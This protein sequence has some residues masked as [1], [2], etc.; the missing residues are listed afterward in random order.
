MSWRSPRLMLLAACSWWRATTWGI[1]AVPAGMLNAVARPMPSDRAYTIHNASPPD[2]T[3]PASR[4]SSSVLTYLVSMSTCLGEWRST[5]APPTRMNNA[6]GTLMR[7]STVPST[8][9]SAVMR[10]TSQGRAIRVN[11]SPS[12]VSALP[13]MSQRKLR[14]CSRWERVCARVSG[15]MGGLG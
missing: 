9:V 6:R 2:S 14:S 10:S 3:S 7:A 11:W 8:I 12:M 5:S 1:M 4:P 15:G 13:L